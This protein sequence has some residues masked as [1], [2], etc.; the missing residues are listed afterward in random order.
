ML[1]G[2]Q[3]SPFIRMK[4]VVVIVVVVVMVG[5]RSVL[6]VAESSGLERT[7]P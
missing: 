1:N 6:V 5:R 2:S 7:K 4:R 3:S